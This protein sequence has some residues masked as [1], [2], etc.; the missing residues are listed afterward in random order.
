MR[1]AVL[2]AA[3]AADADEEPRRRRRKEEANG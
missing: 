1:K 2:E 3:D